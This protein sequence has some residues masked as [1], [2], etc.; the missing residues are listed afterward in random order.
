VNRP[1]AD[2]IRDK[3]KEEYGVAIKDIKGGGVEVIKL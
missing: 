1:L 3:L 2:Q